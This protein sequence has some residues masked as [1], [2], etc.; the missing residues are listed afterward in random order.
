M[1]AELKNNQYVKI[2]DSINNKIKKL[3]FTIA[4]N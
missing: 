1:N 3:L 2:F 4:F